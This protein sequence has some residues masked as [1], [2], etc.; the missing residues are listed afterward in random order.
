MQRNFVAAAALVFAIGHSASAQQPAPAAPQPAGVIAGRLTTDD[1]QP[2]R[3]A[4][5]RLTMPATRAVRTT[6]SDGEGRYS[7]PNLAAGEYVMTVSKPGMLDMV[8]GARRPGLASTGRPI[9]LAAD[10]KLEKVDM[11]VPRGSVVTG[12][13]RDEFG[14]PAF[15]TPVRALR[16]SYHNGARSLALGGNG[17]SDDRGVYRVAG[18][19]PGE[20]LVSAVPRDTVATAAAQMES[21]RARQQQMAAAGKGDNS[22][23]PQTAPS[24]T[25]YVAVYYPGT[26]AGA[27]AGAVAVGPAQEVPGIDIKLQVIHT[28]TITGRVTS[29]ET[30]IPQTRVQLMDAS[31]PVNNVGI[32]W[33]DMRPDGTFSFHGLVPGAYIVTG[34]GT[35]GGQ[36]GMAG[37]DMWGR[38]EV[39][40]DPRSMN[41]VTLAM[42][43]GVSVSATLVASSLPPGFDSAKARVS[44]GPISGPADWEMASFP[45][46]PDA[47]GRLAAQH[48]MP[49]QYQFRVQGLPEGWAVESAMFDGKDA[50]DF[51]LT[52][53]GSRSITGVELKLT[54]RRAEVGGQLTNAAGAP[55]SDYSVILFPSDRRMWVPQSRRIQISVPG[56]DG[57]F[58]FRT[59]PPGEYRLAALADIEPGRQ[60]DPDWLTQIMGA[61][62]AVQLADGDKRT[63]DLRIR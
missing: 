58:S 41:Q 21:L 40:A 9:K 56:P 30:P 5:I 60:F 50:A 57:R 36:R 7:F 22:L 29:A 62:V 48:V 37:G 23:V 32:W 15:N 45:L 53:D 28:A 25:G 16:V 59:L 24:A 35:P 19:T 4:Q 3:K 11:V 10:Q 17:M 51:N 38:A 6:T 49:A 20:Y 47:S 42:Q 63:Q 26:P 34:M 1:G 31:M 12:T 39:T 8:Y 14:D 18:L 55:V 52:I 13:I 61:A 44:L 43:R 2:L 33:T 27:S 46:A 54:S